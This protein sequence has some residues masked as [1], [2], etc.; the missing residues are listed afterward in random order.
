MAASGISKAN[1]A[2]ETWLRAELRD[3][4]VD[5][6]LREKWAKMASGPFSFLRATYWRWAETIL[7]ICPELR[8]AP[9]VLAVGDIHLQNYGMWRDDDGRLVW[10]VND[11]D[12]AAV[13]PY[14]LDLV[15][16]ATS[17]ALARRSRKARGGD[18]CAAILE[19]YRKGLKNP[20]PFVLDEE[21]AWLRGLFVVSEKQRAQFW[22]KVDALP[23]SRKPPPGR[24]RRALQAAMPE[25]DTRIVKFSRRTA[26]TGSLGR[27]RWVAVADWRGGLVLREAK[28]LVA[29]G[30]VRARGRRGRRLL[31]S[32]IAAGRYRA[33]DPWYHA[34]NRLVV[35]RLSP[36]T[37]KI[38][39]DEETAQLL[40]PHMLRAMGYE[41]ANIHLG[42]GNHRR[43]I[44][45]DLG[46]RKG[47]WLHRAAMAAA[48]FVTEEYKD[49]RKAHRAR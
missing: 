26:G 15:R 25:R 17:A 22:M 13:M 40:D 33:P 20:R 32:E 34:D 6:D 8:R 4:L 1:A 5:E 30:W 24:F 16:L 36:N 3:R 21:H 29:S 7:D 2:Y 31:V 18:V 45:R 23:P 46:K 10:G 9:Q 39:I 12:E 37:R 48:A 27:P 28:A 14:A 44:E 19:G 42:T 49:W 41:L 38:D 43:A 35:R 11:F 47:R